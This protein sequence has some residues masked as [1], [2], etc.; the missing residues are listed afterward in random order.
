[1]EHA[2]EKITKSLLTILEKMETG[3]SENRSLD[4]PRVAKRIETGIYNHAIER[5]KKDGT[6]RNW[7]NDKFR[8]L[9]RARYVPVRLNLLRAETGLS[10]RVLK[11]EVAPEAVGEYMTVA[12]M[13]PE[14]ME[15]DKKTK[16]NIIKSS[17]IS[18]VQSCGTSTILKCYCCLR[19]GGDP[20]KV[21]Y[22]MQ[23][24]RRADEPTTVF[25]LCTSCGVR[26]R[27]Q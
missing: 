25:A 26:W 2:R 3:R 4:R 24:T 19:S 6:N 23:Q 8:E 15:R 14:L 18:P 22:H 5:A 11:G 9:Y 27:T 17:I 20:Y 13:Y 12:E 10:A 7:E 16:D 21:T 1:M